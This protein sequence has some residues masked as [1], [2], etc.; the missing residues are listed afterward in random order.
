MT[1]VDNHRQ[2]SRKPLHAGDMESVL[3]GLEKDPLLRQTMTAV[4]I[5]DRP[6]DRET[7]LDRL[8]R[9]SRT[10]PPFRHR[11]VEAPLRLSTPRWLVDP[12]FDLSYH[13]RWIRAPGDGSLDGVLEFARQSAMSGLDQA[14]PLWALTVVEGLKGRRA[15][16]IIKM[17]HVLTDGVG[18]LALLALLG[19]ATRTPRDPGPMPAAPEPESD[20]PWDLAAEAVT[21]AGH[22]MFGSIRRS[23][24]AAVRA[25]PGTVAHPRDTADTISKNIRALARVMT[26]PLRSLSP[27][28]TERRGWMRFA[29]LEFDLD[30]LRNAAKPRG[31]TVNDAFVTAVAQGFARYHERHGKPVERLRA[32]VAV[33]IRK[34]GDISVANHVRGEAIA[35]PV[36]TGD[37]AGVMAT[38]HGLLH[39]L[40]EEVRLPSAAALDGL[41]SALGPAVRPLFGTML[42]HDDFAVSNIPAGDH[43]VYLAG[44]KIVA[45]YPF[46]PLMGTAANCCL[47]GYDHK[48]FVGINAD[49]AAVPD[50]DTLT[51]CIR[52]GFDAVAALADV[53]Q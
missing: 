6:P 13:V 21:N 48:A 24:N 17:S 9:V 10:L 34:P 23:V 33:N 7:L 39:D 43:T 3:W 49:A 14:R 15:A 30:Q 5:L 16:V 28:M 36:S 41:L 8:E 31:C 20:L 53:G 52:E 26:P 47:L 42:K 45:L 27:I 12:N 1:T 19:D 40:K 37:T 4:L 35:I 18:S 2:G 51:G 32:A 25:I 50:L 29:A 38:Y 46:G 11:L 22:R 44:A